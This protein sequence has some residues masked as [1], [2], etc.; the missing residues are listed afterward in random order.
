MK[1]IY[2]SPHQGY[3]IDS[4]K[5]Q[6]LLCREGETYKD[7][8]YHVMSIN[9]CEL[10]NVEFTDE[11]KNLRCMDHDHN[12]G[13]FR[14]VL[15]LVCNA[16][17]DRKLVINKKTQCAWIGVSVC[18]NREGKVARVSFQYKRKGFKTKKSTSLTKLIALSFINILKK[19]I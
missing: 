9:N 8:Y 1:K 7:I 19:P 10:C 3:K 4:W 11:I 12:T 2:D 13:Y 15:C 5:R 18:N 17:H 6:G 14:M 16:Q